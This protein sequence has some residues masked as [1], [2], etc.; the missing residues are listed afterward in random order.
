M[1]NLAP[2]G[3][4]LRNFANFYVRKTWKAVMLATG[5]GSR[6]RGSHLQPVTSAQLLWAGAGTWGRVTGSQEIT[7]WW[8]V[9]ETAPADL[10]AERKKKQGGGRHNP[11]WGKEKEINPGLLSPGSP[12]WGPAPDRGGTSLHPELS[13]AYLVCSNSSWAF[14]SRQEKVG[15]GTGKEQETTLK[16]VSLLGHWPTTE[17]LCGPSTSLRCLPHPLVPK[18]FWS[19]Q[20]QKKDK[21]SVPL[22]VSP[23]AV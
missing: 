19:L 18:L 20:K 5:R 14:S 23:S 21:H 22:Y 4:I 17:Q 15:E 1:Q 13:K 7:S 8:P 2:K 10:P 6:E 11:P 12:S 3:K 9:S 16:L